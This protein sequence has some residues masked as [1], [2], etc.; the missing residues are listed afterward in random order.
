MD[1]EAHTGPEF[2]ADLN[3]IEPEATASRGPFFPGSHHFTIAGGTFTSLTSPELP[4][5][6]R[7]IP[8][9][10]IDLQ[11]EVQ[12]HEIRVDDE[13]RVVALD[14]RRCVRRV[15]SAKV[16]GPEAD[17]TAVVY[18]GHGA[19]EEWRRDLARY[20]AFRHPNIIQVFAAGILGGIHATVFHGD[21]LPLTTFT[22]FYQDSPMLSVYIYGYT[23]AQYRVI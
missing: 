22:D 11:W 18:E 10:D 4:S 21:L 7:L 20:M 1:T 15:Y 3:V 16:Q 12:A 2:A 19:E 13:A 17:M 23:G 6:F 9:G 14:P 5:D 8:L